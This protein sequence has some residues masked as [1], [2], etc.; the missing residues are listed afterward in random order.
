MELSRKILLFPLLILNMVS[1]S[2]PGL[3]SH[4]ALYRLF[5]GHFSQMPL[6]HYCTGP[7][8]S[9][10]AGLPSPMPECHPDQDTPLQHLSRPRGCWRVGLAMKD[11][12]IVVRN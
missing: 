12:A 3:G 7:A 8:K 11:G 5:M 4:S 10:G 6:H 9:P 1:G 2:T